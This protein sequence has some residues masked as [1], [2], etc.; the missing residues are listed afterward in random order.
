[1]TMFKTWSIGRKLM[2]AFILLAALAGGMAMMGIFALVTTGTDAHQI[3]DHD[4]PA[5]IE[6]R[7]IK[8]ALTDIAVA[9]RGWMLASVNGGSQALSPSAPPPTRPSR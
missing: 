5:G 4:M 2:V 1:M 7:D 9:E 6:L 8:L 3:S